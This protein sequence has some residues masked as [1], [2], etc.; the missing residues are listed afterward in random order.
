MISTTTLF[1]PNK[2]P[3]SGLNRYFSRHFLSD[4]D[5][6]YHSGDIFSLS[7]RLVDEKLLKHSKSRGFVGNVPAEWLKDIP[8]EQRKSHVQ[9]IQDLFAQF[10]EGHY[11]ANDYLTK[12]EVYKTFKSSLKEALKLPIELSV[13]KGGSSGKVFKLEVNNK[14]YAL[15]VFQNDID[16]ERLSCHGQM[17]EI[18]RAPFVKKKGNKAFSE[19]YF[20]K[21]NNQSGKDG[22]ALFKFEDSTHKLPVNKEAIRLLRLLRCLVYSHDFSLISGQNLINLKFID[23]GYLLLMPEEIN[24]K[25][26]QIA[27][28]VGQYY[29]KKKKNCQ[30]IEK[31][32]NII[33]ISVNKSISE[34][35]R[36]NRNI[37]NL[38]EELERVF[39]RKLF[40]NYRIILSRLQELIQAKAKT[41]PKKLS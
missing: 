15:K 6:I 33:G 3:V 26:K 18:S 2:V 39:E 27:D 4:A 28:E 37:E 35:E 24:K 20:G 13:E 19:F 30:T 38:K 36:L 12:Y 40:N 1:K 22:F 16:R 34:A 32:K 25:L 10:A 9:K 23:Y 21:V 29:F 41:S 11:S 31:G 5:E 17:M 8:R 14:L 7:E